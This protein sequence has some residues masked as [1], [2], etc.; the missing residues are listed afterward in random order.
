MKPLTYFVFRLPLFLAGIVC[1]VSPS[2]AQPPASYQ[3]CVACH[4]A[5][6][7]GNPAL[8]APALA[9]QLPS[10]LER[11]LR[12]FRDGVRGT[13]PD[14]RYGAQMRAMSL[15]LSD[16]TMKELANYLGG[17]AP[18]VPDVP[19]TSPDP[20]LLRTG[21]D[22]YQARCGACHGGRAEGNEAL[23][24]PALALLDAAYTRRQFGYYQAGVRGSA[25]GDRP[26]RQMQLMA[27]TVDDA[28]Q[29]D[30]ILAFIASLSQ[31]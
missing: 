5:G 25:E 6:G 1:C 26:G 29:L 3:T 2:L 12:Q 31:R 16:A 24:A 28:A 14:D 17:L 23:D 30:A 4:G 15:T 7:E 10:Y 20:A 21:S 22:Y 9:G 11:Q 13:H 27:N 19:N 8:H 18:V